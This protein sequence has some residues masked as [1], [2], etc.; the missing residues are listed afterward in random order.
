MRKSNY[1]APEQRW[2]KNRPCPICGRWQG[3]PRPH[4]HGY[5]SGDFAYCTSEAHANGALLNERCEPPA[6][7]HKREQDGSYRPWTSEPPK[8]PTP[9]SAARRAPPPER[10]APPSKTHAPETGTQCFYYDDKQRI[11]RTDYG[12]REKEIRPQYL[13]NGRW[14]TG[15]GPGPIEYI[16]RRREVLERYDE[17]LHIFEGETCADAGAALGLRAITWRGGT[18]RVNKALEEITALCTGQNV[19]LH[20]DSDVPGRK[21]MKRIAAAIALVASSVKI[22]DYFPAENPEHG[23]RDVDDWLAEGGTVEAL[24]ARIAATP[25]YEPLAD[26]HHDEEPTDTDEGPRLYMTYGPDDLKALPPLE[27]RVKGWLPENSLIG[28]IGKSG[29]MKSFLALDIAFSIVTDRTWNGCDV[30]GGPVLYVA[31]EGKSGIG[32][33][34]TGWETARSATLDNSRFR[35]ITDAP[36]M[37]TDENVE[38]LIA[39]VKHRGAEVVFLDTLARTMDGE[40]NSAKDMGGYVSACNRVQRETGATVCVVH[41]MGWN[42]ERQRGSSALFA[43]M[44][45]EITVTKDGDTVMA[46][47]TKA[48]DFQDGEEMTFAPRVVELANGGTSV[49]LDRKASGIAAITGAAK[50]VGNILWDTFGD[51]GATLSDWKRVCLEKKIAEYSFFEGRKI[52]DKGGF[53]TK[54]TTTRG[55]RYTIT[56]L[57]LPYLT[58]PENPPN[59]E[60]PTK[61][62]KPSFSPDI[63]GN[64][65]TAVREGLGRFGKGLAEGVHEGLGSPK[66]DS[67]AIHTDSREGLEGLGRFGE[68]LQTFGEAVDDDRFEGLAPPLGAKPSNLRSTPSADVPKNEVILSKSAPSERDEKTASD[69]PPEAEEIAWTWIGDVKAERT[70][71]MPDRVLAAAARLGCVLDPFVSAEEEAE[72]LAAHLDRLEGRVLPEGHQ[73]DAPVFDDPRQGG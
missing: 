55:H 37:L 15:D 34:I 62:I 43:A 6:Y 9:I 25:L 49:V 33:R 28:I 59:P 71:E 63:A 24:A 18:G 58:T 19:I 11:A 54:P 44:D 12:N 46:K 61:P 64:P 10:P 36:Q 1:V 42:G 57:F 27:F 7:L 32:Q 2:T 60:N 39:T 20:A 68:G 31:A 52:L 47:V 51:T 73:P 65:G 48:K 26:D 35:L 22:V 38:A 21:A 50:R 70:D 8:Q 56:D 66:S 40:E 69:T 3:G 5:E 45:A 16:Y 72:R 67:P 23:G 17:P 53:I 13:A 29:D 14:Y 30:R 41:H 4:C